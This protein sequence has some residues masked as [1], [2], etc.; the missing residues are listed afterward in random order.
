MRFLIVGVLVIV[1][2]AAYVFS[3][4]RVEQPAGA[5]VP[6]V[7]SNT[8]VA[9]V[10]AAA[11]VEMRRSEIPLVLIGTI[12]QANS[13][14]SLATVK[15]KGAEHSE[16]YRTGEGIRELASVTAVERDRLIF[17]NRASGNLEFITLEAFDP[18]FVSSSQNSQRE[19]QMDRKLVD[20]SLSQLSTFINDA[21][22]APVVEASGQ[23]SGFRMTFVK[24]GSVFEKLGIKAG[25]I[26]RNV[27]GTDLTGPE[28][29]IE[30]FN[31]LRNSSMIQ[32]KIDRGGQ[33]VEFKYLIR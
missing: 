9:V 8:P 17:K 12:V 31:Q 30:L 24:P 4:P 5:G 29:A 6:V 23:V 16:M 22:T 25:D 7:A 14:K 3:R 20:A 28:T 11:D 1:A 27:N 33:P 13:S 10:A 15:F 19:F 21:G 2:V 32:L 26:L 18:A